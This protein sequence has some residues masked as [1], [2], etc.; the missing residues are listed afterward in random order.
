MILALRF[1]AIPSSAL[2]PSR[3]LPS[4]SL[5]QLDELERQGQI[6]TP[7]LLYLSRKPLAPDRGTLERP[8]GAEC[9]HRLVR[10]GFSYKTT[11]YVLWRRGAEKLT[12]SGYTE[13]IIP[14]D[15]FFSLLFTRHNV[16]PGLVCVLH[17]HAH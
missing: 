7:D 14:V 9:R 12:A 10:P 1:A 11:A 8:K 2:F 3:S 6:D 17:V 13:R 15:A 16:G 4:R 5:P